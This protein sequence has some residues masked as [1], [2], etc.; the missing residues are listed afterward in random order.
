MADL[1]KYGWNDTRQKEWI[2]LGIQDGIPA[3]V[4]SV[5]RGLFT[6]V[7]EQGECLARLKASVYYQE[8]TQEELFPV[9]GDFVILRYI[10]FGE[11]MIVGTLKRGSFFSRSSTDLGI[12]EQGV[13]ANFD[14]V[15]LAMSMNQDFNRRR[16]E[17]YLAIAWQSGATPVVLLTKADLAEDVSAW[18]EMAAQTAVGV[19]VLAVSVVTG[20]GM[21]ALAPYMREGKTSILL[22]SSGI[23][24][25]SLVNALAGE[26]RMATGSVREGDEKGR[27]TTTSRQMICLPTGG[28]V[29]DTPGMRVMGVWNVADGIEEAFADVESLAGRCRFANCTH[30]SEPGCAVRAAIESGELQ[31]TRLEQYRKLQRENSYAVMR[32]WSREKAASKTANRKKAGSGVRKKR[33]LEDEYER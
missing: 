19:E 27:H 21:E 9:V 11:S 17:R 7:C 4:T 29:I 12:G 13:A 33:F 24:K 16:L 6:V 3:R 14:Y 22:G 10:P 30:N 2:Q 32:E 26:E 8:G 5:H 28:I 1:K 18:V 23:G 25:S 15:F 31:A 20:E